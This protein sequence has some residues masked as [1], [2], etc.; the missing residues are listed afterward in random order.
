[1]IL[2]I[3]SSAAAVSAIESIRKIKEDIEITVITKDT[4]LY[5]PCLLPYYLSGE[6]DEK[7]LF[8][9]DE[10]FFRGMNI[11]L[12]RGEVERV[13]PKINLVQ[14]KDGTEIEYD[15]L[16]IATGSTP[17]VPKIK[18]INKKNVFFPKTIDDVN[19]LIKLSKRF[20]KAAV[21]GAGFVGLEFAIALKNIGIDTT[22]IEIED[23]VLPKMFD[24]DISD[25]LKEKI[26]EKGIKVFLNGN[27][28]EITGD[29]EVEGVVVNGGR[30]DCDFVIISV[31][32]QPN[33]GIVRDTDVEV[34]S[35]IIVD[36]TM[37]TT[38]ENIYAAGDVIEGVDCITKRRMIN[39]I[40]PNAVTQGKI[41]GLNMVA[42]K[43]EY[44]GSDK[45]NVIN[46]FGMPFVSIGFRAQELEGC[47]EISKNGKKLILKDGRIVG[48][49]SFGDIKKSGVI[50]N[51]IKKGSDASEIKDSILR[52]DFGYGVSKI[53]GM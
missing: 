2:V 22:L 33:I 17:E 7:G 40:W 26:E 38:V 15:K 1:M 49:Q 32:A 35:G 47:V 20:K 42:E 4:P 51:L 23:K 45:M 36:P 8:F 27:T 28:T 29:K 39:P 50:Q 14:L 41:A 25:I 24:K 48:F 44:D 16:L 52:D 53:R 10:D 3:G 21:I 6:I 19:E 46:V 5:S 9:R 43:V 31:G 11:K 34:G 12:I 18:G 13:I 37:R 30:L